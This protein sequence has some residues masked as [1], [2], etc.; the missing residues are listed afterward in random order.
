MLLEL[1][2]ETTIEELR[3]SGYTIT[4]PEA[5]R[6]RQ[7]YAQRKSS[8]EHFVRVKERYSEVQKHLTLE[9]NGVALF[10]LSLMRFEK[11][12]KLY[13][14][15]NRVSIGSLAKLLGKS[16]RQLRRVIDELEK[17]SVVVRE[18]EGRHVFLSMGETF[19]ISGYSPEKFFFVKLYK[20]RLKEVAKKLTLSELG[21]LMLLTSKF[22]WETHLLVENPSEQDN[23]KLLIWKRKHI[24]EEFDI[25]MDFVKRAIP[26]LRKVRAIYEVKTVRTGIVLDPSLVHR[27]PIKPTIEKILEVIEKSEFKKENIKQ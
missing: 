17:H 21:L 18:K 24:A 9:Q 25:S 3:G 2:N 14:N 11:D 12:G 7:G 23:K 26:K 22:H 15:R 5:K 4:S 16:D 10:M 27:Q 13:I 8:N 1:T 6:L 20:A 19:F